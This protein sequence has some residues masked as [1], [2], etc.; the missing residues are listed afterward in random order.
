[1]RALRLLAPVLSVVIGGYLL[2]LANGISIA[3][4]QQ[5]QGWQITPV[6]SHP[7]ARIAAYLTLALALQ[8]GSAWLL[9]PEAQTRD[10]RHAWGRY[11]ARI[12]L[13][14]SACVVVATVGAFV[15]MALLDS[16]SI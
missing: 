15:V 8:F 3:M 4:Q 11:A 5:A 13:L 12:A 6:P 7:A 16:R 14:I 9:M 1:V 2:L 10:A